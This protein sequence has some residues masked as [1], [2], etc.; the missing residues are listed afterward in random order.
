MIMI[1]LLDEGTDLHEAKEKF[2]ESNDPIILDAITE[3]LQAFHSHHSAEKLVTGLRSYDSDKL[4][5]L[6]DAFD[7]EE[8]HMQKMIDQMSQ[9][10]A[11]IYPIHAY[12]CDIDDRVTI[13]DARKCRKELQQSNVDYGAVTLPLFADAEDLNRQQALF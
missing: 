12:I 10:L 1:D 3:L 13:E 2:L 5:E 11:S 8:A 7:Q 6:A 9:K 4:N